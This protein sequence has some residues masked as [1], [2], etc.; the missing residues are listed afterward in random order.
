MSFWR[1]LHRTIYALALCN[2][3][4]LLELGFLSFERK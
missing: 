2:A 4:A 3:Y 1:Q